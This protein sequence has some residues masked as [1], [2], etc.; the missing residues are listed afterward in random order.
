MSDTTPTDGAKKPETDAA[1]PES[2]R[3]PIVIDYDAAAT[4]PE[5]AGEA[6]VDA[7]AEVE[8]EPE[9]FTGTGSHAAVAN[10]TP[11]SVFAPP[12]ATESTLAA[13]YTAQRGGDVSVAPVAVVAAVVPTVVAEAVVVPVAESTPTAPELPV[14]APATVPAAPLPIYVQAPLRP[15]ARSNR[16]AGILIALLSAVVFAVLYALTV[17][18]VVG[19]TSATMSVAVRTFTEFTVLPVFYVPVIFFFLAFTVLIVLV[20]RGG[21]W[22]YVLFGFLVAVAVYFS[23]IGGALLTAQAWNS[24]PAEVSRFLS[25]QWLSPFAIA[26]GVI[27]REVP[28]WAGAWIARRGKRVTVRNVEA[29]QEYER[30][31]AEGPTAA[32]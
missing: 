20:N 27:A 6:A 5:V 26:A 21:W 10:P 16:G 15:T 13:D 7:T 22:A 9:A 31:L 8:R 19:F 11:P 29:A 17:L 14:S 18:V 1:T 28:I 23:Y 30:L 24:T 12:S 25:T 4:E 3:E 2:P 32:R